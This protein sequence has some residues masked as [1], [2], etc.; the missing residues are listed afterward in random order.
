MTG[1]GLKSGGPSLRFSSTTYLGHNLVKSYNKY[2][3]VISYVNDTSCVS[4]TAWS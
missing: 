4:I 3:T 2:G 1:S